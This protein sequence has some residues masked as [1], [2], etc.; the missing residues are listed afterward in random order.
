[1]CTTHKDVCGYGERT[2]CVRFGEGTTHRDV[3]GYGE[4]TTHKDVCGY[5]G[6]A[7]KHE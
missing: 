4:G 2:P 3:C 5:V 6:E 1:M 7:V